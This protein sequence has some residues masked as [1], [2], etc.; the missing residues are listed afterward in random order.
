MATPRGLLA[1]TVLVG[2]GEQQI[3]P[4]SVPSYASGL[5]VQVHSASIVWT[6]QATTI[7]S[8]LTATNGLLHTPAL[9]PLHFYGDPRAFRW[10]DLGAAGNI[11]INFYESGTVLGI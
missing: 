4:A 2:S 6:D 9:G 7:S 3:V 5:L 10:R 11:V 8:V 1:F